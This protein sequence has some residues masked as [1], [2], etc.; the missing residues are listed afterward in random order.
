MVSLALDVEVPDP[1]AAA[2][3]ELRAARRVLAAAGL[4]SAGEARGVRAQTVAEQEREL[5]TPAVPVLVG[6]SEVGEMFGVTRQRVTQLRARPDF[7]APVAVL[8]SGPVWTAPSLR[9]FLATWNRTPGGRPTPVA[10][11][12]AG[13][14]LTSG[15]ARV[16]RG[17]AVSGRS[18]KE[19]TA[20]PRPR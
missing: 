11:P 15:G 10:S 6:L 16:R 8:R 14:A 17:S 1:G 4:P 18:A 12:A 13:E 2:L 19:A 20:R 5:A 3:E 7:P 9:H